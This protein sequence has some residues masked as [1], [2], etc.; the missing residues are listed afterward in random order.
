MNTEYR[1]PRVIA[2]AGCNHKG[3]MEIARQLIKTAAI[4]CNADVIKF[5]KRCNREL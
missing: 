3:D 1:G 2:E 4:Y 5:Q